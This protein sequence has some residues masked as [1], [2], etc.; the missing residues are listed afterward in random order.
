MRAS[1]HLR[2]TPPHVALEMAPTPHAFP[3]V[4]RTGLSPSRLLPP[5]WIVAVSVVLGS[6]LS[7]WSEYS[8]ACCRM[9]A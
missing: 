8:L 5:H 7:A 3:D 4:F 1:A 6:A 2:S 9:K